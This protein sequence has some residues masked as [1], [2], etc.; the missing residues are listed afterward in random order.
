MAEI[1]TAA[2]IDNQAN[3]QLGTYVV[4]LRLLVNLM[5]EIDDVDFCG[6]DSFKNSMI[7]LLAGHNTVPVEDESFRFALHS[8][9]KMLGISQEL[10]RAAR[11]HE[12]LPSGHDQELAHYKE[13]VALLEELL[14]TYRFGEKN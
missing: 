11:K 5:E 14:S 6:I 4:P 3:V 7:L 12:Q 1:Q 13:K 2:A 9:V 8:V 10:L